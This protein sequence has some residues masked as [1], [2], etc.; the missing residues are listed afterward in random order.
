MTNRTFETNRG[1]MTNR[2]LR[3]N[4]GLLRQKTYGKH[5]I[6]FMTNED[7]LWLKAGWLRHN[8][9]LRSLGGLPLQSF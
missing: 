9:T 1:L 2:R 3:T 7:L 8:E 4:R 5:G 6:G